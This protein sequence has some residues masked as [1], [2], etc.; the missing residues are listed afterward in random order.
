MKYKVVE[1]KNPQNRQIPGKYYAS[2]VNVGKLTVKNLS[3][4]I[5]GRSSLTK[6]DIENVLD[7]FLDELPTFLKVGLS[8][9]LGDFGTLRLTL[10]SEGADSPE[11]FKSDMIKNVKVVFTPG[12]DLKKALSDIVFEQEKTKNV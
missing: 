2:A 10:A 8:V 3:K 6:G 5:S 11:D 1:K 9:Q 4:E 12:V 7:N